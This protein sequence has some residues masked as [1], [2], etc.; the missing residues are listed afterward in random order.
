MRG[1]KPKPAELKRLQGN[2]GRRKLKSEPQPA[3]VAPR[4]PDWMPERARDEWNRIV[5]E[6]ERQNMLTIVDGAALEGHCMNYCRAVECEIYL[7]EHGVVADTGKKRP[8]ATVAA[9]CW[10]LVKCFISDLGLSATARARLGNE[11][12]SEPK[13]NLRVFIA[14]KGS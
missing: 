10:R 4:C 5:P 9:E 2:P 3:R 1:R 7:A 13:S 8:E 14:G 12:V 6:L 11:S